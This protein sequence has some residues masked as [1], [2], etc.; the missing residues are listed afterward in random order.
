MD[1]GSGRVKLFSPKTTPLKILSIGVLLSA[2][3]R[4]IDF[5]VSPPDTSVTMSAISEWASPT[6]LGCLLIVLSV[7]ALVGLA[8]KSE[9]VQALSHIALA[10]VFLVMGI[11]S[12]FPVL[13]ILGWGWR[14]P[15][16]YILGSATVH[17]FAAYS[18]YEKWLV[19][20]GR[21]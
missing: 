10:A 16:S 12:L 19:N 21:E 8:I 9:P 18:W 13:H 6:T 7:L 2:L 14:A 1:E 15:V 17:W 20:R 5:L 4:G 3:A 11:V